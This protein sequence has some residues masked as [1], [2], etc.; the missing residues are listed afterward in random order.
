MHCTAPHCTAPHCA[1]LTCNTL[2]NMDD[3]SLAVMIYNCNFCCM[4]SVVWTRRSHRTQFLASKETLSSHLFSS[5]LLIFSSF[6][7]LP[8]LPLSCFSSQLS[9]AHPYFFLFSLPFSSALLL[10]EGFITRCLAIPNHFQRCRPERGAREERVPCRPVPRH[11][12][13][14]RAHHSMRHPMEQH[15]SHHPLR[16]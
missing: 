8:P 3:S 9:S 12:R 5:S 7:L 14:Q 16:L 11:P 13:M 2:C 4:L 1:A 6:L 15:S 10:L